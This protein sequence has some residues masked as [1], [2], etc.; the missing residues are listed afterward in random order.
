MVVNRRR[1]THQSFL[2]HF[3]LYVSEH[4]SSWGSIIAM[5]EKNGNGVHH[6][7]STG[8]GDVGVCLESVSSILSVASVH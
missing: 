4:R 3:N 1:G 8:I 7:K 5:H 6:R 2:V